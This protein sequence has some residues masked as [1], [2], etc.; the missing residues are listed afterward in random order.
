MNA[1][2][3]PPHHPRGADYGRSLMLCALAA[4]ATAMLWMVPRLHAATTQKDGAASAAAGQPTQ[5]SS[6]GN[7]LA[8]A[9]GMQVVGADEVAVLRRDMGKPSGDATAQSTILLPDGRT[10]TL[11][12]H[13]TTEIIAVAGSAGATTMVAAGPQTTIYNVEGSRTG[14]DKVDSAIKR[15]LAANAAPVPVIIRFNLPEPFYAIDDSP[16]R[17]SQKRAQFDDAKSRAQALLRGNGRLKRE[18]RII[19]GMSADVDRASLDALERSP[20]IRRIELDRTYRA[21]LDAS[22]QAIGATAVWTLFD[23]NNEPLT[24]RGRRIAILDT[25]VDYTHPDL[26]GCLGPA[27]KVIGGYDFVNNDPD[28]MDDHGHGTHVAATA[29]GRGALNGV[30]PDAQ[31][32][33]YKVLSA[34]GSG[35]ESGVIAAVD[36]ST[37]PNQDGNPA[38]H[39][40]VGSM[41]L[42][43]PGN[44]DDALSQAVDNAT[45]AGVVYTIAAGNSGPSAST[46]DS[47]GTAR[48]AITVAAACAPHGDLRPSSCAEPMASFSSRG[49]LIWNSQDLQ[50][51]DV[52]APGVMIC[53]ARWNAATYGPACID[54]S[55]FRISGTSMATPHVAGA[56][57][58]VRQAYPTYTPAQVKQ[59]LKTTARDLGM[60][61]NAQG[62]GMINMQAAIPITPLV[63]SSPIS[64]DVTTNPA[65][66]ISS[67]QQ[68]VT[69]TPL[70]STITT[71]TV[72]LDL[73]VPG[74]T[75]TATPSVLNVPNKTSAAFT[76][77]VTADNDQVVNGI[78]QGKILLREG[79]VVK[80][81][82][83]ITVRVSPT[84]T[85]SP[86]L[87]GTPID[88]GVDEPALSSW[89]SAQQQV[90]LTNKRADVGQT[91]TLAPGALPAG[92]TMTITPTRLT[93]SPGGTA[94]FSTSL[95]ADNARVPNG[96]YA[97]GLTLTNAVNAQTLSG[98][99]VKYYVLSIEDPDPSFIGA[100][101]W[102]H[103]R[104]D[105]SVL[106]NVPQTPV[107]LYANTRG[108]FDVLVRYDAQDAAGL[109]HYYHVVREG[110]ALTGAVARVSV[111]RSEATL[112]V[113]TVATDSSGQRVDAL[114]RGTWMWRY[115]PASGLSFV[116]DI[117]TTSTRD[118]SDHYFSPMSASYQYQQTYPWPQ[119]PVAQP[120]YFYSQLTGISA[121]LTVTNAVSD[122]KSILFQLDINRDAGSVL[123]LVYDCLPTAFL[124][125]ASYDSLQRLS[126]PLTQTVYSLLPAGGFVSHQSDISRTECPSAGACASMTNTPWIDLVTK[127]RRFRW[128]I[129]APALPPVQGYTVYNG[130]GP[131]F[132]AAQFNNAPTT[133]RVASFPGGPASIVYR[134]DF[135][136]PEY[137]AVPVEIYDQQ[138]ARVATGQLPAVLP[139]QGTSYAATIQS[140]ALAAGGVYELRIPAIPYAVKG[141]RLQGSVSARFN[142]TLGDPNPPALRRVYYAANGVRAEVYD[143]AVPNRL[144]MTVDPVGG[145][146]ARVALSYATDGLNFTP[147]SVTNAGGVY[148]ANLPSLSGVATLT[149]RV[150]AAD[151]AQ[152][153][154]V[155]TFQIPAGTAPVAYPLTVS[156][157][158]AGTGTVTSLPE[159][160]ACGSDC[161]ESYASGLNV[162]LVATPT[163]VA[164]YRFV[165]WSGACAG[166]AVDPNGSARCALVMN[167]P[168]AVTA[169]FGLGEGLPPTVTIASPPDRSAWYAGQ[170]VPI[171]V[172]AG[173]S[174]GLK[175]I[176]IY[177]DGALAKTCARGATS[178]SYKWSMRKV[179]PGQYTIAAEAT[180]A[181]GNTGRAAVTIYRNS[182]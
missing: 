179:P 57:A 175:E 30:A 142:T 182:L 127:E 149:L 138:G 69:V 88:Y 21:I 86:G 95:S 22:T 99:F 23:A 170:S 116:T 143:A 120:H 13:G 59:L 83:P 68:N 93:L 119:Q 26:G 94:T 132:F 89:T 67:A 2:S 46:I 47:P 27:C 19:N 5:G 162:M 112:R 122:F 9:N 40:D 169:A 114:P 74:L 107:V 103:N 163:P 146:L 115:L 160:V 60:S 80:G 123:P 73:P 65:Q 45:A 181:V 97:V 98:T 72:S 101:L 90:T 54:D 100:T 148:S 151:D 137:D 62:A 150:E 154:L 28:P 20:L 42:G 38:D 168:K 79:T 14:D 76:A 121:P 113:Q 125:M 16:Q 78:Y 49:P 171:S 1:H 172:T 128:L 50:K 82:M 109:H 102:V 91:V 55:H 3:V 108:P 85:A 129:P 87:F 133:I 173:D 77:T 140:F 52:A 156:K 110:V 152:N 159:G 66:R 105:T 135:A 177:T 130:L 6:G 117:A 29:A 147:L 153:A 4:C 164:S 84:V 34:T 157:S 118:F 12:S 158:G 17:R 75:G 145:T 8:A 35:A 7:V 180:D 104:I 167:A 141:R 134:Q 37:D 10:I 51:P 124:C 18:L 25:G 166:S 131:A 63:T 96:V 111:S 71:L 36:R 139:S 58:L 41:S 126:L 178:C 165:G 144:E 92:V 61:A 81:V 106:M 11:E 176:R 33:A 32:I 24:G 174:S 161:G 155:H 56:A 43:S 15:R 70:V 39:V 44:P 48:T 136:L 31:I 64:W 53:A